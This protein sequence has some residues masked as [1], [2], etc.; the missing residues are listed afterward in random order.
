MPR[1]L[2]EGRVPDGGE[3]R[4][5]IGRVP[6]DMESRPARNLARADERDAIH[7]GQAV[8]AIAGE[9]ERPASRGLLARAQD[10]DR[11]GIARS[12]RQRPPVD[13]DPPAGESS[14]VLGDA[15]E[16]GRALSVIGASAGPGGRTAV[17]AGAGPGGAGR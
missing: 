7:G 11:D 10:R 17:Q 8:R 3:W 9:A 4:E 6:F 1:C 12:E 14:G 13:D 2:G 5:A 16:G 15:E